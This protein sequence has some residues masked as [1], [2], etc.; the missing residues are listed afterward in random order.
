[1][2]ESGTDPRLDAWADAEFENKDGPAGY[3]IQDIE[4]PG[5]PN[6]W[7][8]DPS[9]PVPGTAKTTRDEKEG[10]RAGQ[11]EATEG[12]GHKGGHGNR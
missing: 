10:N 6:Y 1:V 4:H 11:H 3:G 12:S 8:H 7:A 5:E 2:T 9:D